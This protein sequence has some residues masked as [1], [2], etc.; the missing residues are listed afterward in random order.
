MGPDTALGLL[1][2]LVCI[3]LLVLGLAY[4]GVCVYYQKSLK[5]AADESQQ[6]VS[7]AARLIA[8]FA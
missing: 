1:V 2:L 8:E 5:N 4:L 7:A 6:I 3:V